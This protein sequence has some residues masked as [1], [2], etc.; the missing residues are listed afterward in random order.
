MYHYSIMLT[1]P[2]PL[3]QSQRIPWLMVPKVTELSSRAR[4]DAQSPPTIVLHKVADCVQEADRCIDHPSLYM[5]K[6]IANLIL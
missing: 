2:N 6:M 1:N 5:G 4:M 3:S